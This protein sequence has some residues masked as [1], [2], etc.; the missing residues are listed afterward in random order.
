MGGR[1]VGWALLIWWWEPAHQAFASSGYHG[2]IRL[3][4]QKPLV[5]L[6]IK[7]DETEFKVGK[8]FVASFSTG[9]VETFLKKMYV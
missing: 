6:L 9:S 3:Q 2:N 7:D 5:S 1:P 4:T 8:R